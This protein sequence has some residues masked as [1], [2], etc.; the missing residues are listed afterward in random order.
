M[1]TK[2]FDIDK[3]TGGTQDS[4]TL[5]IK[6]TDGDF[7]KI[8]HVT[9]YGVLSANNQVFYYIK[10]DSRSFVPM[11]R[12]LYFGKFDSWESEVT[13][14]TSGLLLEDICLSGCW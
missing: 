5:L 9:D 14:R 6:W 10:N 8:E 2:Q 4:F 13:E 7:K 12:V 3:M 1:S 11:K